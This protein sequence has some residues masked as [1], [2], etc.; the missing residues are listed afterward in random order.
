[1]SINNQKD[2]PLVL[3]Y[4]LANVTYPIRGLM[5]ALNKLVYYLNRKKLLLI[6]GLSRSGTT[7]LGE[8]LA[9]GNNA[10]YVHEPV[11]KLLILKHENIS[12]N[13]KQDHNQGST[14][15]DFW[16]YVN[17]QK[18]IGY[19]IHLLT[20][21][22]LI[23]GLSSPRK[24]RAI[25]IKSVTLDNCIGK[26]M[27]QLS[28]AE[29]IY[30]SRHPC[31]RTE[32]WLRQR[33]VNKDFTEVPLK[34]LQIQGK[35]W[36][37]SV[38]FAQTL[39]HQNNNRHW[40]MFETITQDP[41]P[42]FKKLYDT[43]DLTWTEEIESKINELTTREDTDFYSVQRDARSQGYKWQSQ[44]NEEQVEAIRKGTKQIPTGIYPGF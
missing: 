4:R 30:I 40:V 25:C 32:S 16:Q 33:K 14:K 7:M 41:V 10:K 20:V 11:K 27:K 31:G 9:L 24:N 34:Q 3:V 18:N 21:I 44:L 22:S 42:E 12:K 35:I 39:F 36:A 6:F 19:K 2:Y 23:Y 5:S 29:Y 38:S 17:Q 26:V 8:F 28:F 43:L 37:N 1:M 15:A 13:N